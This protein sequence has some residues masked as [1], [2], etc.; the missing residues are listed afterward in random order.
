MSAEI[1]DVQK[2]KPYELRVKKKFNGYMMM[3]AFLI[4]SISILFLTLTLTYLFSKNWADN[5][6]NLKIP[7]VFY[8]DTLILVM[9][10]VALF[11]SM[12]SFDKDDANGYKL[13]LYISLLSGVCF[14]FGQIAGWY[15]LSNTGF[16]LTEHRSGAFLYVISGIHAAHIIGGVAFLV[17]IFLNASKKLK[18]PALAVVYFT[19]PVPKARLKLANYYWHFLGAVWLYLLIFFA[20]VK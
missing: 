3:L 17:M 14:L 7:P 20:I 10:S 6:L 1:K 12:K 15:A 11:M 19:D 2:L 18:D 9:G 8:I 16:G 4:A 13:W 5:I